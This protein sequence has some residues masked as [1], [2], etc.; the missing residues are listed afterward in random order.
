MNEFWIFWK[1]EHWANFK[2]LSVISFILERLEFDSQYLFW[3]NP[4]KVIKF[5]T[6]T[7]AYL[8]FLKFQEMFLIICKVFDQSVSIALM[9]I[10]AKFE[11][12]YKSYGWPIIFPLW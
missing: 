2:M 10:E 12:D 7:L 1:E 4:V 9:I 3:K 5:L 8:E 6:F 11:L